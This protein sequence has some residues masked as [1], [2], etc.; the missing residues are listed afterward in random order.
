[1]VGWG[2]GQ[3]DLVWVKPI[4]YEKQELKSSAKDKMG[5]GSNSSHLRWIPISWCMGTKS[6]L[7]VDVT[8][9]SS[10]V[11]FSLAPRG[12]YV[13]VPNES[14]KKEPRKSVPSELLVRTKK[15]KKGTKQSAGASGWQQ[16]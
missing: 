4:F 2:P 9:P 5:M 13:M 16:H 11:I 10:W 7:L 14:P 15:K 6:T 8:I 1:M 12:S 3:P